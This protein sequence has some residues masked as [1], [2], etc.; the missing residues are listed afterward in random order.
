[1]PAY[2]LS[3]QAKHRKELVEADGKVAKL[4]KQVGREQQAGRPREG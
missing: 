2:I 1:M 3:A 4:K